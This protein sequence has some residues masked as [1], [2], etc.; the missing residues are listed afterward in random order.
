M[1]IL[2]IILALIGLLLGVPLLWVIGLVLLAVG[3]I[4]WL[5]GAAGREVGGRRHYY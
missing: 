2:G 1:I 3:A 4:L 5:A